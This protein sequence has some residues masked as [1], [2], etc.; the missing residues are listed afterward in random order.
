[1]PDADPEPAPTGGFTPEHGFT[2][3][4]RSTKAGVEK[5]FSGPSGARR[6]SR[7]VEALQ[8]FAGTGYP[9]QLVDRSRSELR[10]V[11]R[12]IRGVNGAEILRAPQS[13]E[14]EG[15]MRSAGRVLEDLGRDGVVHGDFGPQNLLVTDEGVRV[16][17][18]EWCGALTDPDLDAFWFDFIVRYHYPHA[19]SLLP[20]FWRACGHDPDPRRGRDVLLSAFGIRVA[21]CSPG[22]PAI[23]SWRTR[24]DWVMQ[25]F[26]ELGPMT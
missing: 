11:T 8:R 19:A 6:W 5:I 1:M 4:T 18:W 24:R 15:L 9:P 23:D 12:L 14:A 22:S 25:R 21:E 26:A 16:I 7:E 20:T 3:D 17:D 13:T 10:V 2:N